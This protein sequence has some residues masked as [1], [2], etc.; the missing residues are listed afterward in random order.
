MADIARYLNLITSEHSDKPKFRALVSSTL[1]KID[2]SDLNVDNAFDIDS[3]VG[4]QLDVLG[5]ILGLDRVLTF[6]PTG[7]ISSVL[8]DSDYRS[9]LKA[10]II[11]N[12]WNGTLETLA[13]ALLKWD[14]YVQF[15][16]LDNQD[17]SMDIIV[18]GANQFQTEIISHG[19]V[20]P[21]TAGV[22]INYS[23]SDT[24]IFAYDLDAG[25]LGGYDTG[26][27]A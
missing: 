13:D 5:E 9:L 20:I 2:I 16:V 18:V 19:Y 21:K 12:Q 7:G 17:M 22:K 3:A 24:V 27:W 11:L 15:S 6:Q 1:S 4:A 25:T 10:R 14:S 23:I 8:G 26:K